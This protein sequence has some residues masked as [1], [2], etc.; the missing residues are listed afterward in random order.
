MRFVVDQSTPRSSSRAVS[1]SA[2]R[3][4]SA[5]AIAPRARGGTAPRSRQ[6]APAAPSPAGSGPPASTAASIPGSRSAR[7]LLTSM[8]TADATMTSVSPGSAASTRP[9]AASTA[10]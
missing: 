6:I 8:P 9:N 5:P 1:S 3:S 7:E 10:S 4:G 2:V